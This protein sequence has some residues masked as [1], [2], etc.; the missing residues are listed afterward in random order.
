V[1]TSST[2]VLP[3]EGIAQRPHDLVVDFRPARRNH[4]SPI[5]LVERVAG[6]RLDTQSS[7]VGSYLDLAR[8]EPEVI[9]KALGDNQ[10]ACLINGCPHA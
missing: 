5:P 10:S 1:S 4:E 7:A 8:S 9:A 6:K 3:L 2:G